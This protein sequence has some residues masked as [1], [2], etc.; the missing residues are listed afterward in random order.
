MPAE[1]VGD[2][3]LEFNSTIIPDKKINIA[4]YI[5]EIIFRRR[6]TKLRK[7]VPK[8]EF[9]RKEFA[10]SDLY[11][12]M[13]KDY[14]AELTQVRKILK[15]FSPHVVLKYVQSTDL[16]SL[17]YL[18]NDRL[19]QVISELFIAQLKYIKDLDIKA[20]EIEKLTTKVEYIEKQVIKRNNNILSKGV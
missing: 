18:T 11:S 12:E 14:V 5:T 10:S 9:W 3:T 17:R 6:Y 7:E 13:A 20:A 4:N 15:V 1:S 19:P 8:V 16:W 2:E